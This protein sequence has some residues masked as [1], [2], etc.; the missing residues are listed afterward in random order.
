MKNKILTL[1]LIS[2]FSATPAFAE[3]LGIDVYGRIRTVVDSTTVNGV[4]TKSMQNN[5]SHIGF[6]ATENLGDGLKANVVI[7]TT[8]MSDAPT[9][10]SNSFGDRVSTVGLSY[11]N[12]VSAN[13]G[14]DEHLLFNSTK[15]FDFNGNKYGTLFTNIHNMR[16]Q[17]LSNGIFL[18]AKPHEYVSLN[19][20]TGMSEVSGQDNINLYGL[21]VNLP[22]KKTRLVYTRYEDSAKKSTSDFYGVRT[23]IIEGTRVSYSQSSNKDGSIIVSGKPTIATNITGKVYGF[24]QKIKNIDLLASY[25]KSDTFTSATSYG[26]RYNFSKRTKAEFHV[27][28]FNNVVN[29]KDTKQYGFVLE[30][31]F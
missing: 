18:S 13:L 31:N 30:H 12:F 17:R 16:G 25:G 21:E 20:Q 27:M 8:I 2:A 14:R 23:E 19:Y 5:T 6:K 3:D 24:E 10:P 11:K 1:A 29:T 15:R 26:A 28:N 7:E 22:F 9:S 4:T